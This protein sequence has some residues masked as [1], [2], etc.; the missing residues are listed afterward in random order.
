M[1]DD[2]ESLSIGSKSAIVSMARAVCWS[3]DIVAVAFS[4]YILRSFFL[5]FSPILRSEDFV[6]VVVIGFLVCGTLLVAFTGWVRN[7]W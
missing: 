4:E 5:M 6:V 7:Q 3:G 1:G 2:K